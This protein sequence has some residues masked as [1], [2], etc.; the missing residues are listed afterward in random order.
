MSGQREGKGGD[1]LANVTRKL[2]G[3]LIGREKNSNGL[4][5]VMLRHH[6]SMS[7]G[8]LE[9]DGGATPLLYGG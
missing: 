1:E 6:P 4:L 8:A 5:T 9:M 2:I 3:S 7:Q